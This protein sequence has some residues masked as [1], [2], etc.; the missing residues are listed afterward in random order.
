MPEYLVRYKKPKVDNSERIL[1]E[2]E[3]S[4]SKCRHKSWLLKGSWECV[5]GNKS[6]VEKLLNDPDVE[7]IF[8][9]QKAELHVSTP[10]EPKPSPDGPLEIGY[11]LNVTGVVSNA[12]AHGYKGNGITVA[13]IDTGYLPHNDLPDVYMAAGFGPSG[14]FLGTDPEHYAELYPVDSREYGH[15]SCAAGVIFMQE[16]GIGGLGVAPEANFMCIRMQLYG[17]SIGASIEW[18]VDNGADVINLSLGSMIYDPFVSDAFEHAYNNNVSI[19]ASAGNSGQ[20]LWNGY[21]PHVRGN[22]WDQWDEYRVNMYKAGKAGIMVAAVHK[23]DSKPKGVQMAYSLRLGVKR[24]YSSWGER[25]DFAGPTHQWTTVESGNEEIEEY[26]QV[27]G[28]SFSGPHVAGMVALIRQKFPTINIKQIYHLLRSNSKTILED[29]PDLRMHHEGHFGHGLAYMPD[30]STAELPPLNVPDPEQPPWKPVTKHPPL[31]FQA[32]IV[33]RGRNNERAVLGYGLQTHGLTKSDIYFFIGTKDPGTSYPPDVSS[34]EKVF[35]QNGAPRNWESVWDR[36]NILGNHFTVRNLKPNTKYYTLYYIVNEVDEYYDVE[37]GPKS[38]TTGNYS[39][40][41]SGTVVMETKQA[42]TVGLTSARVKGELSDDGNQRPHRYL[43]WGPNLQMKNTVDLGPHSRSEISYYLDELKPNTTYYYRYYAVGSKNTSYGD[44]RTFT[45]D[46]GALLEPPNVFTWFVAEKGAD[47]AYIF[48]NVSDT[49]GQDPFRYLRWGKTEEMENVEEFGYF[50]VGSYGKTITGLEP[51]TRYYLQ[52]YATNDAGT[53]GKTSDNIRPF[54]TM[55]ETDPNLPEVKE[56]HV[57][58]L[59][60]ED[61]THNSAKLRAE[62][63]HAGADNPSRFIQWGAGPRSSDMNKNIEFGVGAEGEFSHTITG[64]R[65][66]ATYYYRAYVIS[67]WGF[68]FGETIGFPTGSLAAEP[69]EEPEEY[70]F[71]VQRRVNNGPWE[72]VAYI[73]D[74]EQMTWDDTSNFTHGYTY[75]YQVN[76]TELGIW[77]NIAGVVWD[78]FFT[79][80]GMGKV[81][82]NRF[83]ALHPGADPHKA[84]VKLTANA[85]LE[86]TVRK[87]VPDATELEI[88]VS[89]VMESE[90]RKVT[91]HVFYDNVL[92]TLITDTDKI[93]RGY[94]SDVLLTANLSTIVRKYVPDSAESKIVVNAELNIKTRKTTHDLITGIRIGTPFNRFYAKIGENL[95]SAFLA[96]YDLN[97]LTRK[98]IPE[99]TEIKDVVT[100]LLSTTVSKRESYEWRLDRKFNRFYAISPYESSFQCRADLEISV[101]KSIKLTSNLTASAVLFT[102]TR[103]AIL[104][105]PDRILVAYVLPDVNQAGMRQPELPPLSMPRSRK[106]RIEMQV[107]DMSTNKYYELAGCHV[108]FYVMPNRY[109]DELLILKGSGSGVSTSA[110]GVF[111]VE[112]DTEDLRM[113]PTNYVYGI[114][115]TD[116]NKHYRLTLGRFKLLP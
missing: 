113:P 102:D 106:Q 103:K 84:K 99:S 91:E 71:M 13:V 32:D 14:Q 86:T 6:D 110:Y 95:V 35:V 96:E 108:A 104:A 68:D 41:A 76:E 114:A 4:R 92:A 23:D 83:Y 46:D 79:L 37:A 73:V 38:F 12:H 22:N 2:K 105:E 3:V 44:M 49:G 30:L 58:T 1:K 60:P 42:T 20:E 40:P 25:V 57:N 7:L 82:F 51:D 94:Q 39:N 93:H 5:E 70:A 77:S 55:K 66:N 100:A 10:P 101:R 8:P 59:Y 115:I 56:P 89:A 31:A 53:G 85:N 64:L 50:G 116:N 45:T 112:L 67:S 74:E 97:T 111:S 78:D 21:Y 98:S 19:V 75:E 80:G 43:E 61:I 90:Y 88:S 54:R 9:N 87:Y 34:M 27:M 15:G 63:A 17:A 33:M 26:R 28:T 72:N 48:G 47:W 52:A 29:D 16:N 109:N 62:V 107:V 24:F 69:P 65:N 18:A 11:S 36:V 81:P